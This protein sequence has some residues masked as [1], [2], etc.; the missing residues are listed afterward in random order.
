MRAIDEEKKKENDG[1]TV[2]Q[3]NERRKKHEKNIKSKIEHFKS[4]RKS[5]QKNAKPSKKC[6]KIKLHASLVYLI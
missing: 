3:E 6:I 4:K 5:T 1:H 2:T